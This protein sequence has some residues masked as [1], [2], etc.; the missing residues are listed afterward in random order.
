MTR[1]QKRSSGGRQPNG[2][3]KRQE[4]GNR[5]V[6]EPKNT[7]YLFFSNKTIKSWKIIIAREPENLSKLSHSQRQFR[8]PVFRSS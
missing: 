2:V 4:E 7:S 1:C 3:V 5:E 8:E 6:G